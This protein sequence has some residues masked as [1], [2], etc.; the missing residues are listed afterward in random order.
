MGDQQQG[1]GEVG[2]VRV[3]RPRQGTATVSPSDGSPRQLPRV[4]RNFTNRSA[5]LDLLDRSLAEDRQD[6]P[7]I[8]LISG[9]AGVGKSALARVWGHRVSHHFPQGQLSVD[10]GG[11]STTGPLTPAEVLGRFLRAL[12]VP[13]QSLPA[14]VEELAA[15]YRTVTTDRPLL[16]LLDNA[17]TFAQLDP[18]LPASAGSL[19]IVTSR[20]RLGV[21]QTEHRARIVELAP[22]TSAHST[23]LLVRTVGEARVAAEAE[24]A[25]DIVGAC[26][27][28]PVALSVVTAKL[29]ERPKLSL[30]KVVIE[31]RERPLAI[32]AE[33]MAPVDGVFNWSYEALPPDAA[34]LY[35]ALGLHP[36]AEFGSGVA[37]ASIGKTVEATEELLHRLV[38]DGLLEDRGDDRYTFHDLIRKHAAEK[39]SAKDRETVVRRML[40]W[41]L[42]T[43]S[44]TA[45]LTTPDQSPI[46]YAYAHRPASRVS[47]E[48]REAALGWLELER[49]NLIAAIELA[50]EYE[51]YELG[52]QLAAAMWPLFLLHK[53]YPNFLQ[54]SQLGVRHA[55]RWGNRSAEALMH[56]RSGAAT[57]AT[58]KYDEAEGHYRR[59]HEVALAGDDPVIAIRSVEG[60]GLVALRRG[61]IDAALDAFTEDLRISERL[62]RP[63]DVGLALINLGATLVRAGRVAEAVEH[64]VRARDSLAAQGD[65]YNAARARIELGRALGASGDFATARA[66]LA[67]AQEAMHESGSP[68]EEARTLQALG[69]VAEAEGDVEAAQ[70]LYNQALPIFVGLGRP[71]ADELRRRIEGL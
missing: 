17:G 9:P 36:G 71:E 42:H 62:D 23:E 5:E 38:A 44:E 7:A 50:H 41:Y 48:T 2:T 18:L 20:R 61:R 29:A 12:G 34:A 70:R 21:L 26:G 46:P 31:L 16:V 25:R 54:V 37:A 67:L 30:T 63:H 13:Q 52:W 39:T 69:E 47:F 28:L 59:G 57:R 53:H 15:L 58:G 55:R 11:F 10:L 66:E 35:G 68:F 22:L 51:M 43:A 33:G 1:D 32:A 40:E 24:Q 45:A 49:A 27:G 64:L 3:P 14:D 56:N 60:L 19:V 4:P 65:G 8:R 6:G